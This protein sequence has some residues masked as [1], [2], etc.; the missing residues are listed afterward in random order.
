LTVII[1]GAVIGGVLVIG[2]LIGLICVC[3]KKKKRADDYDYAGGV[4]WPETSTSLTTGV[5]P[6][7]L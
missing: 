6:G 1:V 5:S 7:L 4:Q 2:L 3:A